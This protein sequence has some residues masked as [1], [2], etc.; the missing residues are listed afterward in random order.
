M[1]V[2]LIDFFNTPWHAPIVSSSLTGTDR[3]NYYGWRLVSSISWGSWSPNN[4]QPT[5]AQCIANHCNM[6]QQL[7]RW[8]LL[9]PNPQTLPFTNF[10]QV[11]ILPGPPKRLDGWLSLTLRVAATCPKDRCLTP[12]AGTTALRRAAKRCVRAAD[13]TVGGLV[14][15]D[16]VRV[17][18]KADWEMG[19][20]GH[21]GWSGRVDWIPM[22]RCTE[23]KIATEW[24]QMIP[25]ESNWYQMI[26]DDT[27]WYQMIPDDTDWYQTIPDDTG[28]YQRIPDDTGWYQIIQDDTRRCQT[29]QAIPDDTRRYEMIPDDTRWYQIIPDDT[30]RP[31]PDDTRRYQIIPDDT[32]WYQMIP[33]DT[34]WFRAIPDDTRWYQ[35]IPDDT[36][37]YRLIPDDT[38]WYWM[39]PEDTRWY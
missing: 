11:T 21:G 38:R 26:P 13:F 7:S 3:N 4:Q 2:L 34:R 25:I 10:H 36:G 16:K 14:W 9:A 30:R 20:V 1:T 23:G 8:T 39:I 35:L 22:V 18:K 27:N 29:I 17:E 15:T 19:P 37:W 31:I 32:K 6:W 12:V 5:L 28:W 24:Y 33:D